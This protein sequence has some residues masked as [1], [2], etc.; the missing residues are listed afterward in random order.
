MAMK[1]NQIDVSCSFCGTPFTLPPNRLKKVKNVYCRKECKAKH[2]SKITSQRII[3]VCPICKN[4]FDTTARK[5]KVFCSWKC[6]SNHN[7]NGG[8]AAIVADKRVIIKC[9]SCSKDVSIPVCRK[10]YSKNIFCSV[11][12]RAKYILGKNNPAFIHGLGRRILYGRN[13][14]SQRRKAINRDNHQCQNCGKKYDKPRSLHVHHII[15]AVLFKNDY[16]AAND[17]SNLI[18]LCIKCHEIAE[19]DISYHLLEKSGQMKLDLD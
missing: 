16:E 13:W 3:K 8:R 18:T 11:K 10:E 1:K 15:P 2:E 12:C 9:C 7:A 6:F 19:V 4:V 14:T 17:L 5:N